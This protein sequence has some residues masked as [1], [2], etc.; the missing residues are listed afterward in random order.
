MA[1]GEYA[2][3]NDA[4]DKDRPCRGAE[5]AEAMVPD[6]AE[7]R[8]HLTCDRER[9]GVCRIGLARAHDDLMTI[10]VPVWKLRIAELLKET[11]GVLISE[12]R[13]G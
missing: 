11:Y 3:V 6:T 7:G 5:G 4:D 2:P 12:R 8:A 10:T 1:S 9:A 13:V